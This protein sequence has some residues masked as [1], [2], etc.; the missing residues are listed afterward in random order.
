M[1]S[2]GGGTHYDVLGVKPSASAAEIR[3]AYL[4]LARQYHPDLA[5]GQAAVGTEAERRMQR[6]NEAWEV[7]GDQ[8][9]RRGYDRSLDLAARD[10]ADVARGAGMASPTFVPFDESEDPEDPAA[11]HDIPYGD[12][13]PL[14]TL[15]QVS[16]ALGVA[17]GIVAGVLG[18]VFQ[19]EALLVLGVLG[20]VGGL[21]A[22]G[23]I[24]LYVALR[25]HDHS[26][27]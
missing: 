7:L 10:A 9:R 24:P 16:P 3:R 6:V 1:S 22:F 20:V 26:P 21:L 14:P 19:S 4:A 2:V 13:T 27:H 18:A 5:V 8:E 25:T 23:A 12:G 11:E 15:V 17:L